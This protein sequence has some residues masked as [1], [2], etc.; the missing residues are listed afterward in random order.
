MAN[1]NL[2]TVKQRQLSLLYR[3]YYRT[4][5]GKN[6]QNPESLKYDNYDAI[7]VSKTAD[8]PCDYE[9]VMGVPI[10]FLDKYNPGQFE[11]VRNAGSYALDGFSLVGAIYTNGRKIFKRIL[12][13]RKK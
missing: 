7:E 13:R 5:E 2:Q 11:I 3:K 6:Y 4:G 12:I 1:T 8:I 10:I 9:G